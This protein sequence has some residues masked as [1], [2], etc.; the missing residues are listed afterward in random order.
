MLSGAS[1]KGSYE[2]ALS[3][4]TVVDQMLLGTSTRGLGGRRLGALKGKR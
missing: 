3:V 1:A 2:R 4:S